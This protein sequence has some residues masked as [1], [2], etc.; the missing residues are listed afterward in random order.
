MENRRQ[1]GRKGD[2]DKGKADGK[3]GKWTIND[4]EIKNGS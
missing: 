4:V 1:R 2:C 3:W